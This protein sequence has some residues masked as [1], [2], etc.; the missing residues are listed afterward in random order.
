[1][2]MALKTPRETVD[3]CESPHG[4]TVVRD[5][6]F[7]HYRKTLE[8]SRPSATARPE[9]R[10]NIHKELDSSGNIEGFFIFS[11]PEVPITPG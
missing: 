5:A 2:L 7:P 8:P 11:V 4:E 6:R 9:W 1:M 3:G 10:K